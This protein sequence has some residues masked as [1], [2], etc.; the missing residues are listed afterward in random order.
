MRE[1]MHPT[2]RAEV[3]R[4]GP[5][6]R[7]Q[8]RI[9]DDFGRILTS[10]RE[11][12]ARGFEQLWRAYA[13][14]VAGYLRVQGASEPDDLTNEVFAQAFRSLDRFEGD[15]SGFRSWLFTIAHRRLVDDRRRRAR[16]PLTVSTEQERIADPEG[17]RTDDDALGQ[18]GTER[19]RVICES[20]APDQR[21]V[22]LLRFV[23]AM[24]L[25]ETAEALGKTVT[26]VK[27][28]QRRAIASLRRS[29]PVEGVSR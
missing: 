20:L 25:E 28:L 12:R 26:A 17:G 5:A 7:R 2:P 18:L 16:R 14:P 15:E 4:T 9:G 11:G 22:I 21:D 24:T 19:V 8:A 1:V 27:A 13:S 10:A 6:P 29:W 3:N 23:S